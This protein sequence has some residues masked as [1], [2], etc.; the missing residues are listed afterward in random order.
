MRKCCQ[1]GTDWGC[2]GNRVCWS[3]AGLIRLLADLESKTAVLPADR[4]EK[5]AGGPAVKE[6]NA[7]GGL[8]LENNAS[9]PLIVTRTP[10]NPRLIF[11]ANDQRVYRVR[12]HDSAKY[13]VGMEIVCRHLQDDVCEIAGRAPRWRGRW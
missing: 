11:A 8:S 5:H 12:V 9:F 3:E 1:E 13:V 4:V 2:V 10:L 7:I 6:G